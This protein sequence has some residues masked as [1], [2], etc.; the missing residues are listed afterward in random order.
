M[1]MKIFST[2]INIIY[3]FKI[4]I[5]VPANLPAGLQKLYGQ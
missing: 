3:R 5:K 2:Y 1:I 4:L